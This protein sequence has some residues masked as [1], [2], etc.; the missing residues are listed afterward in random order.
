[1]D[2]IKWIVSLF[3]EIEEPTPIDRARAFSLLMAETENRLGE[4]EGEDTELSGP[5]ARY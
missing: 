4:A 2:R 1:M 5:S 3:D